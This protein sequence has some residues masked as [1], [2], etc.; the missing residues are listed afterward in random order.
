MM[1]A[2]TNNLKIQPWYKQGW[3]WFLIALPAAAVVAGFITYAIAASTWD[4]LVVDDYDK[5]GRE[6]NKTVER[7]RLAAE[8]GLHSVLSVD[9][10]GHIVLKVDAQDPANIPQ[11]VI[12]T[13]AHPTQQGRDQILF[14]VAKTAGVFESGVL[15]L[16]DGRWLLQIEDDTRQWRMNGQI[17]L[18]VEKEITINPADS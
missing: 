6:I 12:V 9:P 4:G 7:T 3:P 2:L 11:K 8:L 13:I 16:T 10:A 18:P 5:E 15:P 1:N 17:R 14:L